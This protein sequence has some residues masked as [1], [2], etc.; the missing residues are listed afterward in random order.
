MAARFS[1]KP[2]LLICFIPIRFDPNTIALGGVATGSINAQLAANTAGMISSSGCKF[3]PADTASRIGMIVAVVAVLL[4][5]SVRK[6]TVAVTAKIV[7]QA[8]NPP[9]PPERL[10]KY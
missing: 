4:V 8:G 6:T 10:A 1:H 5:N 2:A 9:R 7:A 3:R